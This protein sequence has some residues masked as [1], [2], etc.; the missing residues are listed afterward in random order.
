MVVELSI[1]GL[2][3]VAPSIIKEVSSLIKVKYNNYKVLNNLSENNTELVSTIAKFMSVK[4]LLTGADNPVNLFNFFQPPKLEFNDKKFYINHID[5]I[6]DNIDIHSNNYIFKGTVGQGKSIFLRSLAIQDFIYNKRIPVFI[7]LKNISKSKGLI[8]LIKDYLGPW[9]GDDEEVFKLILKSGRV[10]IFLD[11]FDEIDLDLYQETYTSIDTLVNNYPELKVIITSRPETNILQNP[12]FYIISLCPYSITEQKGLIEKVVDQIETQTALIES[13]ASSSFEVRSVLTT[14]LMVI[15]Y[16]KQ[17]TF[18]FSVPKHV[19]DFYRNIFDVVT[20]THDKSKGIEKRKSFSKLNQDQLERVFTRFC[21]ESFLVG[22]TVFDRSLF[23]DLLE[24]SLK[25]C[26]INTEIDYT[27]LIYDYTR[28][29]CLILKDGLKYTFIHKSIQE[30]YVAKFIADL[31]EASAKEVIEKKFVHR[32]DFFTYSNASYLKFL[33]I[34]KPYYYIKYYLVSGLKVYEDDF[35]LDLKKDDINFKK[36]VNTIYIHHDGHEEDESEVRKFSFGV[37]YGSSTVFFHKY[38]QYIRIA[39]DFAI[40]HHLV[41]RGGILLID[42]ELLDQDSISKDPI[43]IKVENFID[44]REFYKKLRNSW[45]N[46]CDQYEL[47][48]NQIN[49][50][51]SSVLD[52]IFDI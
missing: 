15:L 41:Q 7:E 44:S 52:E 47:I 11:A 23:I 37:F 29:A 38:S 36:F 51:E 26:S 8:G 32:D 25:K 42:R 16:I 31:P 2:K 4:T 24:K 13:I 20:F 5:E 3:A 40:E 19:S 1:V 10:S 49:E 35:N 45:D 33:E 14:P 18:G 9:I 28:F 22:K 21:F 43:L 48:V 30:Y 27:D 50:I 6:A 12:S 46:I 39:F 34:I 17:Y